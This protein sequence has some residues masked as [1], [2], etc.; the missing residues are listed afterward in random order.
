MPFERR[1]EITTMNSCR[2]N[3]YPYCPQKKFVA[4]YRGRKPYLSL[5]DFKLALSHTPED[6]GINFAGFTEPFLNPEALGMMEYASDRG[7]TLCLY[8]TLVGLKPDDMDRLARLKFKELSLHLP[9]ANGIAHIPDGPEEREVLSRALRKLH[10]TNF[11]VMNDS[12]VPHNRAGNVEELPQARTQGPFF[13][14]WLH[15]VVSPVMMPDGTCVVC[16]MD[17]GLK[18]VMGNL[19]TRSYD[20]LFASPAWRALKAN[21]WMWDG[22]A[23]CRSCPVAVTPARMLRHARRNWRKMLYHALPQWGSNE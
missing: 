19:L 18:H 8:T 2:V 21:A 23:I 10:S 15:V 12:F 7:R 6:V 11:A 4:A 1:L 13:C 14:M 9:D 17:W 3:C 16:C 22:S 5:D 20:D